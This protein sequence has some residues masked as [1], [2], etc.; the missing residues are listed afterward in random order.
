MAAP[1]TRATICVAAAL[2]LGVAGG[3]PSAARADDATRTG[4]DA[5]DGGSVAVSRGWRWPA[6]PFRLERPFVAP[7]HAY[8]PGHRGVDLLLLDDDA[9]QTPAP[10]V[11]AFTGQVA[12]RPVVTIDHGDGL[13][14]T[15]E[16]VASELVAGT[17][18]AASAPV[19]VLAEGGHVA[20][21]V[22]HFGVRLDGEYIN[23]LVLLGGVPRAVL[24]P[25]C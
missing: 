18:V 19:G 22:L 12:G 5:D 3:P 21:G 15:L 4:V 14:T 24:L 8:G 2:L 1:G 16:P 7:A 23:P 11:V 9:V 25:C 10:G 13:V 6:E 20:A 17:P